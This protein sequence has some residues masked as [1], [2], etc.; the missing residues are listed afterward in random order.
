L[1]VYDFGG[2]LSTL[3]KKSKTLSDKCIFPEKWINKI[4]KTVVCDRCVI[5]ASNRVEKCC[6]VFLIPVPR[7]HQMTVAASAMQETLVAQPTV[8]K[9]ISF[10]LNKIKFFLHF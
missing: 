6:S 3:F 10:K 8:L 7:L 9:N 5:S 1:F 2:K 4:K